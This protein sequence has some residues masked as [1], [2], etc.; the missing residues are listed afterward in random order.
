VKLSRDEIE[1]LLG[2]LDYYVPDLHA[3]ITRTADRSLRGR[4][5]DQEALLLGLRQRL[6]DEREQARNAADDELLGL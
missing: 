6:S 5:R 2:V 1:A 4:L 3:E